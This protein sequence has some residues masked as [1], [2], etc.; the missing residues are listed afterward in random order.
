M[1]LLAVP[2]VLGLAGVSAAETNG[3]NET[4]VDADNHTTD[5]VGGTLAP[6]GKWPD[7]VAVL[8]PQGA[9]TG[10]LIAP[11]VV[12]TAG[13]C[14]GGMTQIIANTTDYNSNQGVRVAITSQTAYP[15][16]QGTFD[17][18]VLVLANPVTG[19]TPRM[20][21]TACT[22][23]S[24][25][26]KPSVQLVG[27]G[28]TD[29]LA[30]QP[31]TK[32]YEVTVPVTDPVCN[33]PGAGCKPGAVINGKPGEFIA[34]GANKDSCNGDSGGPV[35]LSTPR[36]P[37]VI[38]AVSRALEDATEPCGGGGIYVRTDP[39]VQWIE[40]TTGKTVAKDL[41]AASPPTD[42]QNPGEDPTNPDN[43]NDGTPDA[44]E[45]PDLSGGC[46]SSHG[47]GFGM[48]L[49]LGLALLRRR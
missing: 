22:F 13:H 23:S 24:F 21:G 9:C 20:V 18:G 8:G 33:T 19:V 30:Q 32:L 2:L 49:L 35:Y 29:N 36:G 26:S 40:T 1:R 27:F 15:N 44:N 31:N 38:G 12:L 5:I 42:P 16:W 10:T 17:I 47:T 6:A 7:T 3:T 25:M 14:I 45:S 4:T 37:V 11:D 34:G 48:L 28:A 43:D 41:C 46:A 39:I